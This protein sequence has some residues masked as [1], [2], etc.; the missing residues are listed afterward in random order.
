MKKIHLL[1]LFSVAFFSYSSHASEAKC[2]KESAQINAFNNF[3]LYDESL[4]NDSLKEIRVQV[5][6]KDDYLNSDVKVNFDNCGAVLTMEGSETKKFRNNGQELISTSHVN[7]NKTAKNWDYKFSFNMSI[8]DE[9]GVENQLVQQQSKG[10]Y[11]TDNA[12]KIYKTIGTSNIVVGDE[13][14]NGKSVT[15]YVT[16][17]DGKLS[18]SKQVGTLDTDNSTKKYFYDRNGLLIKTQTDSTVEEFSYDET[19]RELSMKSVAKLFTTETSVTTCKSWNEFGRC[20]KAEIN[21]STFFKGEN[22]KKDETRINHA[23]ITFDL[24]Y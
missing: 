15:T 20:T 4:P 11:L 8:V 7:M 12:G 3:I 5:K 24:I 19:G 16:N 1:Y 14:T 22:G 17:E 13:K 23:E 18:E 9:K 21:A 6:S 10:T 2:L